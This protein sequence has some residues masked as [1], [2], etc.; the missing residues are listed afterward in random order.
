MAVKA[1][2]T[3]ISRASV[4]NFCNA[5]VKEGIFENKEIT[6]KGGHRAVYYPKI[7]PIDLTE[8]IVSKVMLTLTQ[9]FA[10]KDWW[11]K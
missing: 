1:R 3:D 5:M 2:G 10:D 6:G 4:I 7:T 8:L 11:K 9:A